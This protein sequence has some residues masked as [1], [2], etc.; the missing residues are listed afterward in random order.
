MLCGVMVELIVRLKWIV[1][2]IVLW[3]SIGSMFGSVRLI[4][5]VC[6][7]GFVL[8]CVDVFEKIFEM[9]DSC[10]CVLRLIMI[11]Y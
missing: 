4:G 5:Y 9:V 3:F 2:L 11:F 6:V 1:C 7:F 10:V 8:N